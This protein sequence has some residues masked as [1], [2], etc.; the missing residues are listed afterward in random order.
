MVKPC[1]IPY[2]DKGTF[3]LDIILLKDTRSKRKW[4]YYGAYFTRTGKLRKPNSNILL[5]FTFPATKYKGL[6]K[7]NL[8]NE[9]YLPFLL[10]DSGRR[11][12]SDF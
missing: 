8:F 6:F 5:F 7:R 11:I 3:S 2:E 1:G 12:F 10:I 9:I 4:R